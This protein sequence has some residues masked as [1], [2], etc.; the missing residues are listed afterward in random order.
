MFAKRFFYVSAGLFL[1]ALSYHLGA[2]SVEAQVGATGFGIASGNIGNRMIVMTPSGDVYAREL[3]PGTLPIV[4]G[5]MDGSA[6]AIRLGNFWG[7][8]T[9]TIPQTWGEVKVR[10]RK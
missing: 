6:P 9:A 8:A 4:E 7:G 2:R 5:G 3:G 1:L 10:Y